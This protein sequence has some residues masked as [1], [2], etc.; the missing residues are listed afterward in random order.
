MSLKLLRLRTAGQ[1]HFLP[2]LLLLHLVPALL[3]LPP[4]RPALAAAATV[5]THLPGFDG[6]LPFNLETGYVGVEEEAGAELFYYFVES[7]RSPGTDPLLLWLTGGPRCS[8][9]MGLAFEIGPLKFVLAPYSGGL[10]E[11]VYNPYS[12]TKMANI[13]LLDSPVGSG[14]SF[15]RDPKGYDVGDY[16]S[17][18]Q[19]QTFLNKWFTDHPQYLSNPFY[20]GGDSYAGKV[21]PLIGQGIS[22]GIDVRQQP[23]INLKGYMVGNPI[24]DPKFDENYKIPS[25]HGFGII[26]DQ[27]YESA[28]KNC[29]GDYVTPV[30]KM[31]V[32]VLHT[33]NNL[34]SEISIEHILYNKCDVVAPKTIDDAS[35]R[36][37]LLEESTQLN[38]PPARP[39]VDCFTYGYYLAYF[40]M[41]NNMTRKALG[42]KEG[43][44]NEWIQCNIGLP[45]TYEIPSSIPY[46]LNLTTRG[47]RALVY[48]GDHDLEAPFLGTQAW[49]RSLNFSIVDEWRAWHLSGQAAG[50]T[51]E[52]T[53]N[54]TFATV[55][56]AGH[57]AP[58]YRPKECFAMAQRKI[59]WGREKHPSRL[60]LSYQ[61]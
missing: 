9:I 24:T 46:H 33:I 38:T 56:G 5:V 50:F 10:P 44:T 31:C 11:L 52:Y 35:R 53:N 18:S 25:A 51:I 22:E 23:V 21:I 17:S 57:T 45:Y 7:E 6:P 54:M 8:V 61:L 58:E 28:V 59:W 55:K 40:W 13:L 47:Y 20:I 49:I 29:K 34:I 43:T 19:V 41:N 26:S 30:N 36:K 14:F 42:I 48:S 3:L 32:E 60:D 12:W 2:P 37:F 4:S 39:T 27:I 15:A 1:C 16:S